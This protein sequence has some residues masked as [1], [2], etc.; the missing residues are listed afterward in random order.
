MY[1]DRLPILQN[2]IADRTCDGTVT[3][4]YYRFMRNDKFEFTI[5]GG[6]A[7]LTISEN[8]FSDNNARKGSYVNNVYENLYSTSINISY[9]PQSQTQQLVLSIQVSCSITIRICDSCVVS[10]N[11]LY[12]YMYNVML[13]FQS[14]DC[15][16]IHMRGSLLLVLQYC[17]RDCYGV[18]W[19]NMQSLQAGL[20]LLLWS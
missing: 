8:T 18:P 9:K 16:R 7:N 13:P 12:R 11:M 10:K 3:C 4:Y 19:G 20:D 17:L 1:F 5:A 6:Y 15:G 2:A 14:K